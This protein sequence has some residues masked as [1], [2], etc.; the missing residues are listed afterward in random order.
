MHLIGMA[1]VQTPRNKSV[2][3]SISESLLSFRRTEVKS[4]HNL[5]R[6]ATTQDL[7]QI[8]PHPISTPNAMSLWEVY[9]GHVR[10]RLGTN[11]K[12]LTHLYGPTV[13]QHHSVGLIS[14]HVSEYQE[15][16][17]GLFWFTPNSQ[18]SYIHDQTRNKHCVSPYI[19][20]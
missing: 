3:C 6:V 17:A 11:T 8:L 7:N 18:T 12:G 10:K 16:K 14:K 1:T 13:L 15:M 20:K 2:H 19:Q 5:L 9:V 4:A